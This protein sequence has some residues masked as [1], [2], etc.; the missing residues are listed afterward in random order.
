MA[1]IPSFAKLL[2]S[3]H[4]YLIHLAIAQINDE[5]TYDII[6]AQQTFKSFL[7][8]SLPDKPKSASN[9]R[10]DR[11]PSIM[12]LSNILLPLALITS[13]VFAAPIPAVENRSLES[14]KFSY[15]FTADNKGGVG[16]PLRNTATMYP[17]ICYVPEIDTKVYYHNKPN[18]G[19]YLVT[20]PDPGT[21]FDWMNRWFL[22][23]IL[24]FVA[25]WK[26]K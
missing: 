25:I 20:K 3:Y 16:P 14:P 11:R 24:K 8:H 2:K 18:C 26:N 17:Y 9:P 19:E 1:L 6:S 12:Q 21:T 13:S 5:Y 15:F 7:K 23:M 22:S 4:S 10:L